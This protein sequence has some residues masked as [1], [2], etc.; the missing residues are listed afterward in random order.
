MADDAI[1]RL[2]GLPLDEFVPERDALAKRLRAAGDRAGA[3][4]VKKLP[5]PTRAAWAV[6]RLARD[7]PADVK[8]LVSAGKALARA[9]KDLLSG[10]DPGELRDAAAEARGAVDRLVAAADATGATADKVR[11]T[12]H[13]ATVDPEVR[14]AVAAGRLVRE[15]S[16][17][18]FGG[19]DALAASLPARR[20]ARAASSAGGG[21]KR[22][23]DAG[24]RTAA[25]AAPERD[26]KAEAAERRRR[27]ALRRAKEAEA[28]AEGELAAAERALAQ[29]EA[30]LASRRGDVDSARVRLSEAR[31]RRERAERRP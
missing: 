20:G 21:G 10:A 13:A 5:K 22:G 24:A 12:L 28:E 14:D 2:Y 23:S 25:P 17:A 7:Q 11:S 4:E 6:N 9:Q 8:A 30:A 26:A 3:D 1:D 31:R 29:M 15:R 16:A 27:D 18:G 19:L